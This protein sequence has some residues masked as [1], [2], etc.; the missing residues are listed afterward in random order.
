MHRIHKERADREQYLAQLKR[1]RAL[2]NWRL[3]LKR[4]DGSS[5]T[6]VVNSII[7]GEGGESQVLG[8]MVEES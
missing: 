5:V 1:D 2:T 4:K 8:T 3:T 6:G 7:P